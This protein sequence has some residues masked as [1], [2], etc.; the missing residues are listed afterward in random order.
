MYQNTSD[1]SNVRTWYR[2]YQAADAIQI[3]L[4]SGLSDVSCTFWVV[5]FVVW[6]FF[7]PIDASFLSSSSVAEYFLLLLIHTLFVSLS[8]SSSKMINVLK[9]TK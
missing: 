8:Y 4:T 1:A 7:G 5:F 6:G 9:K 3:V 2:G